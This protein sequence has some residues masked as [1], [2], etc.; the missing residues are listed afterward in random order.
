MRTILL[1]ISLLG[2]SDD[3]TEDSTNP[4]DSGET[5]PAG[6]NDANEECAPG[7]AG[8]QGEGANMLPGSD[9]IACH[10]GAD[11]GDRRAEEEGETAALFTAAGTVYRDLDGAAGVDGAIVSITDSTGATVTLTTTSKGNFYT[12]ATLVPPLTASVETEAGVIEMVT[13]VETGA[14]N[15]CHSCDGEVGGKINA[16]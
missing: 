2:C 12:S 1:L 7:V 4:Q 9:C 6:C 11:D 16:L 15:T 14:C 13:A 5:G 10:T 3:K 8:C